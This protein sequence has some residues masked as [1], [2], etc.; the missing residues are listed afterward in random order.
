MKTIL[1]SALCVSIVLNI[2]LLRPS[3][4]VQTNQVS[5]SVSINQVPKYIEKPKLIILDFSKTDTLELTDTVF[6]E[7]TKYVVN[8]L[9]TDHFSKK[10]Y[11]DVINIKQKNLFG[12]VYLQQ[13]LYKNSIIETNVSYNFSI[14]TKPNAIG[15][16]Y[17]TVLGLGIGYSRDFN[18]IVLNT[19]LYRH[20]SVTIGLKYKF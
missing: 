13:T 6:I 4:E 14:L 17:N 18:N 15:L 3:N 8:D 7:Q 19:D 12:E 9:L 20:P 5:K 16:N 11:E 10:Y 1:L 2:W